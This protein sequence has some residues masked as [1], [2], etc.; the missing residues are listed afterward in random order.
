M[1]HFGCQ[2]FAPRKFVLPYNNDGLEQQ[3]CEIEKKIDRLSRDE[4]VYPPPAE[5]DLRSL[6]ARSGE[7]DY[8]AVGW[9]HGGGVAVNAGERQ[10]SKW[11]LVK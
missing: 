5:P 4:K 1:L 6:P 2:P 9:P 8:T 11:R 7:L 10:A 3:L